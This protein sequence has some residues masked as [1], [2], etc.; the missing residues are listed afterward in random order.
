MSDY[1]GKLNSW[2][3]SSTDSLVCKGYS[4]LVSD[5]EYIYF[6]PYF[7]GSNYHGRVLRLKIYAVFKTAGSWEAYDASSVDSLTCTGFFGNPIFDGQFVYFIPYKNSVYHG[8]VLRYDTTKP[9][10]SSSSWEAY[11]AGSAGGLTC[12]GYIG[13][14]F[15]GQFIYFSP[16]RNDSAYHGVV[17]RYDTSK[18]FKSSSSWAAFDAGSIGGLTTK[19]FYGAV[20]DDDFVYF[21]PYKSADPWTYH[22]VVLRYNRNLPF[23][24]AAS[25]SSFDATGVHASCK[26][27]GLPAADE[28][29]LY[30]PPNSGAHNRVLRYRKGLPFSAS[31]SWDSFDLV[32]FQGM[33]EPHD[34]CFFFDH[35]VVF[36]PALYSLLMYDK[37]LPFSEAASWTI[38]DIG[39]S[40]GLDTWGYRGV[41]ADPNYFFFAPFRK[42]SD[43][44]HGIAARLRI[45]PCPSQTKPQPGTEHPS[46]YAEDDFGS[47][48]SR[49]SS[50][51]S[52]SGLET[53]LTA[54]CY[55]DYGAG[56]FN[57]VEIDFDIKLTSATCSAPDENEVEHGVLSLSNKHS[58]LDDSP[59]NDDPMVTFLAEFEDGTRINQYI[60][61]RQNSTGSFYAISMN[62]TYYCKLQRS[63]NSGT[64][65]LKIYSDAA[66]TTL[67]KTLTETGFSTSRKWRYIYAIRSGDLGPGDDSMSFYIE[68]IN[69]IS[70]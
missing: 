29:F 27:F 28:E 1:F 7:D 16:N 62:T 8:V 21:S 5:G 22:G 44:Y 6:S 19:G 41:L 64:V 52:A 54:L 12:K 33:P 31:S 50:R 63:A 51:A 39:L 61:L 2:D 66:R 26:G 45:N 25:W 57:G 69:V 10:K 58:S 15:D 60:R 14:V 42:W 18:P 46:S 20:I 30:F 49:S 38:K 32:N 13:A 17:L 53:G 47:V 4:G 68:N 55:Q 43:N 11:D 9:F 59:I 24:D 35:F 40:E 48:I 34:A 65:T 67:L 70:H 37:D 56:A 36:S 3:A 23:A